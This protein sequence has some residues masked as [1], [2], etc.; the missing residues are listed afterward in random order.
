[1]KKVIKKSSVKKAQNGTIQDMGKDARKVGKGKYISE[2]GKYKMK[3]KG[4]DEKEGPQITQRRT[5]K[6]LLTGAPKAAGKLMKK[7][8]AVKKAKSGGSFPDL[9]K[10]GK[11]TKA[12]ILKGRGVIAKSGAALKKQAAVAIAMKK[13]GKAPKKM[14]YGGEAASMV[15]PT[16]KKGG[17]M[18]KAQSG[19]SFK[20]ITDMFGRTGG[21]DGGMRNQMAASILKKK[22]QKP[23]AGGSSFLSK[24]TMKKG[25]ATKKCKYGCK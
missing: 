18:K 14:Q 11:I 20:N 2:D 13:A 4:D 12:D 23:Q 1:M 9:N 16:M 24:P 3:F 6:G 10:D 5:L 25:G 19:A 15:P 7:G 17:K 21:F 8:G 22:T